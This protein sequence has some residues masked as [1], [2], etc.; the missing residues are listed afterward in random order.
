M[1][2]CSLHPLYHHPISELKDIYQVQSWG[3]RNWLT[4]VVMV[5][6]GTRASGQWRAESNDLA[7]DDVEPSKTI[8]ILDWEDM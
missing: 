2:K 4:M 5:D 1:Y 3:E 8:M 6:G 7:K